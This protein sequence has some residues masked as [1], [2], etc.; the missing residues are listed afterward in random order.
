[1]PAEDHYLR[2]PEANVVATDA[3]QETLYNIGEV[4]DAHAMM[5][6]HGDAGLGKTLSVNQ[7]L[8]DLAPESTFRIQLRERPTPRYL[9]HSL[10]SALGISGRMPARPAEF[11]RLL[12]TVLAEQLRIFVCDEAQ[13]QS[14]ECFEYWRHLWDD[15]RTE[16]AVIFVGGGDCYRVL[17]REP[18][19]AS[20]IFI[21]QE[22][23]R[24]S[25]SQVRQ[26]MPVFHPIWAEAAPDDLDF[27][28][29][30][31]AHGNFRLW[32]KLTYHLVRMLERTG[33]QQVNRPLLLHVFSKLGG[34]G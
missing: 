3:L 26:V 15:R 12:K 13:W 4:I 1:M 27:I 33:Q 25:T 21:W 32:A 30:H 23:R 14:P 19:L 17:R 29:E 18:M 6:I 7:T 24:L 28:D 11:D 31:A 5:C 20:R 8:R 9:R 10:F 34:R 22:F 2:L 16:M